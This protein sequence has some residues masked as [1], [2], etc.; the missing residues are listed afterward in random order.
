MIILPQTKI[1]D[2]SFNKW[3]A[4]RIDVDDDG[5]DSYHYYVIPLIDIDEYEVQLLESIPTLFSS[6][7]TEFI[8]ENG[9]PVYTLRLFD[10]DL[11]EL[12]FEEEVEILYKLLTKKEIYLK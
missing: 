6:E 12:E 1:T 11:P 5:E 7:S 8:D 3:K 10:E 4:H 9:E 2:A